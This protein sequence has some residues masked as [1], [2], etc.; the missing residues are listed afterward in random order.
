MASSSKVEEDEEAEVTTAE[1][2]PYSSREA[3]NIGVKLGGAGS[4][5][6]AALVVVAEVLGALP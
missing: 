4:V 1:G 5:L 3:E 2:E 6:A